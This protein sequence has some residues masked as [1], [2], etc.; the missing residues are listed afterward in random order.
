M[1]PCLG[2]ESRSAADHEHD[3]DHEQGAASA[4]QAEPEREGGV[5]LAQVGLGEVS[6]HAA[7][8]FGAQGD[9]LVGHRQSVVSPAV[10]AR[11]ASSGEDWQAS[12]DCE[13]AWRRNS[14]W[15]LP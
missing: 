15:A 7:D 13:R 3:Y 9:E 12:S 2:G 8:P 5:D 4:A 1:S 14:S 10:S 11:A 6:H